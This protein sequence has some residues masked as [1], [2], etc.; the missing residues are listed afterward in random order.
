MSA[1]RRPATDE[2]HA[3]ATTRSARRITSASTPSPSA[4][5]DLRALEA[6]CCAVPFAGRHVLRGRLRHRLVDAARRTPGRHAGWPPTST[7][8]RWRSR[9]PRRCRPACALPAVDA[10][11]LAGLGGASLR[12]RL[13]RLLVEPRAAGSACAS[14]SPC[15]TRASHRGARSCCSTTASSPAAARRSRAR[16]ADG[17]TYQQRTLDD[18]SMHEVLKNF[19]GR[20]A[21]LAALGAG[22][23]DARRGSSTRTT[24]C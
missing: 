20:D 3:R 9:G 16:D 24:G 10:Y 11:T 19:P 12:R 21:G 7:P 4:R 18:G 1:T 8:R 13:R 23:R 17:N 2:T 14:G 22:V 5:R 6:G 15:C